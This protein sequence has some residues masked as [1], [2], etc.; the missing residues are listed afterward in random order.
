M[1]SRALKPKWYHHPILFRLFFLVPLQVRKGICEW[2]AWALRM[3]RPGR[4]FAPPKGLSSNSKLR[5]LELRERSSRSLLA[6]VLDLDDDFRALNNVNHHG[7]HYTAIKV[8][9]HALADPIGT[10]TR[11]EFREIL[12]ELRIITEKIKKDDEFENECND[13]KFAAMVIDRLCL[14]CFT[15]FTVVSTLAILLSAPHVLSWGSFGPTLVLWFQQYTVQ[16][17]KLD[18]ELISRC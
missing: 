6:N 11:P 18:K 16:Y 17:A 2:L 9:H 8:D 1:N 13:W 12:K 14:W 5:D 10:G 15:L 7:N 4:S 3:K